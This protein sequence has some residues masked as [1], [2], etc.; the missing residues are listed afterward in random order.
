MGAQDRFAY[1]AAFREAAERARAEAG[2]DD[3]EQ[4]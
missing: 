3:T 2:Q 4:R 1:F